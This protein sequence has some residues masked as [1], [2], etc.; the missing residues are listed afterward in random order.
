MTGAHTLNIENPLNVEVTH[1]A[2]H[3]FWVCVDDEELLLP[4]THFPWFQNASTAQIKAVERPTANHLYW[5]QLDV[6][7]SVESLR[8]PE[9]FPLMWPV[10]GKAA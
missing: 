9:D 3:G 10:A 2:V 7:L 1:I 5:P 8:H 6:D 4:Y